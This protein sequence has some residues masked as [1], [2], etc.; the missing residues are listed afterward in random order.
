MREIG[1]SDILDNYF[2]WRKCIYFADINK[3]N[4]TLKQ[5]ASYTNS[6]VSDTRT[7][8]P[9]IK[10]MIKSNIIEVDN[11]RKPFIFKIYGKKLVKFLTQGEPFIINKKLIKLNSFWGITVDV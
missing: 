9:L 11:S 10:Y 7:F 4:L 2:L 3:D 5:I 1:D 8:I 6:S